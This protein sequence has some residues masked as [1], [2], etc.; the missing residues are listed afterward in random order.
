MPNEDAYPAI[1]FIVSAYAFGVALLYSLARAWEKA[2][3]TRSERNDMPSS[4]KGLPRRTS[5]RAH[6][7]QVSDE[8]LGANIRSSDEPR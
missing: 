6:W 8:T 3:S 5:A 7:A 2:L 4:I 1:I